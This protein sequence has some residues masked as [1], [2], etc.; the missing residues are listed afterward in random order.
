MLFGISIAE[1]IGYLSSA[2]VAIS[3]VMS[4]II[5]L[6]WYNLCG[7]LLFSVYGVLISAPP[8]AILNLFIVSVDVYFL[9]QIYT[10]KE[11]F[12][13]LTIRNNNLYLLRFLEFY[14][15]EINIYFPNFT[16]KPELNTLSLFI[17]RNMAVAGIFLAREI[18]PKTLYVALDFVIP[19]Y[20][21]FKL[22]N[23]IYIRNV[24][25]F[26]KK[27][28]EKIC[29]KANSEAHIKYLKHMNFVEGEVNG[30]KYYIKHLK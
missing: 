4:S 7:A 15:K 5:R 20:R 10:R 2:I 26:L 6:R 23:F 14:Q 1:W 24:E 18:A 16:Y 22:A 17:L 3:M 12:E 8:V 11:Y 27:D 19:E 25:Y 29:S 30:E 28:Y 9:I 13:L 21:D